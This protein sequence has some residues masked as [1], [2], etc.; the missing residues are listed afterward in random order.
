[1]GEKYAFLDTRK[2]EMNVKRLMKITSIVFRRISIFVNEYPYISDQ[3][4]TTTTITCF[5]GDLKGVH[6][7]ITWSKPGGTVM[8]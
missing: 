4:Q 3:V 8:K 2:D 6:Q 1:M 7:S 5:K